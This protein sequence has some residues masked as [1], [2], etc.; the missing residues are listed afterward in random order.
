[1]R[2]VLVVGLGGL[3]LLAAAALTGCGSGKASTPTQMIEVPK[4]GPVAAGAPGGGGAQPP[5]GGAP[6]KKASSAD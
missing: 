5:G 3:F 6:P 4:Q 1:M 2:R